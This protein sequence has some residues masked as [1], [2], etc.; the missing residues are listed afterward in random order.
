MHRNTC[1]HYRETGEGPHPDE[2][3]QKQK[4]VSDAKGKAGAEIG[5][6]VQTWIDTY[7]AM[8]ASHTHLLLSDL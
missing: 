1:A 2:L 4:E 8:R 7:K 5:P 6:T 3:L